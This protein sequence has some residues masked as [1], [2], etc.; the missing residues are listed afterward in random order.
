VT[1]RADG[2]RSE[3]AAWAGAEAEQSDVDEATGPVVNDGTAADDGGE[4]PIPE[5][6][7]GSDPAAPEGEAG[8]E[9]ELRRELDERTDDLK[10]V[11]AEYANYRRRVDRDRTAIVESAKASVLSELLPVADDLER[12]RSHGDLE[13]GPLKSFAERITS[14]LAA[15]GVE[16]F[17]AE[18]EPFD[19]AVHEAV[20]DESDGGEQVLGTV[21][22]RGYRL[23]DRVLRTA[24]VVVTSP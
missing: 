21:L 19:P 24:M 13:E 20:Q 18:G 5:G 1:R 6:A 3:K 15:Q 12:A 23:G 11:T 9:A 10:R 8:P 7:A 22:R 17:G 14:L 16:Q 4:G 2:P